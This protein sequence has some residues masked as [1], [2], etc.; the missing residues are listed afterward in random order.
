M[1]WIERAL[2][3]DKTRLDKAYRF[4]HGQGAWMPLFSVL[5]VSGG[6]ILIVLGLMRAHIGIVTFS[7]TLGKLIRYVLLVAATLGI[8]RLF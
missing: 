1:E 6:A 7:M 4:S 3:V 8:F 5:P 2:K